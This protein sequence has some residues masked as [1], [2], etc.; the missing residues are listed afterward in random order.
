ME[1]PQLPC[2]TDENR[3]LSS[4]HPAHVCSAPPPLY[5]RLYRSGAEAEQERSK[6]APDTT[7]VKAAFDL[8]TKRRFFFR[9]SD[10]EKVHYHI[11]T[12]TCL[13][14]VQIFLFILFIQPYLCLF[15]VSF[16]VAPRHVARYAPHCN[17]KIS[18]KTVLKIKL[19]KI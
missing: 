6:T 12:P 11:Q 1:K 15:P 8:R 17:R 16:S 19:S 13:E 9:L 3:H 2:K 5:L 18:S 7:E 4:P 14:P 10:K